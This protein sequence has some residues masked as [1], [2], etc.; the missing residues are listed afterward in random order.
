MKTNRCIVV[1]CFNEEAVL[2]L[3]LGALEELLGALVKE[4]L[5]TDF[6][7]LS[8]R[9]VDELLQFREVNLDLRG[10]SHCW[11]SRRRSSS[12][13]ALPARPAY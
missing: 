2:P 10:P 8:R 13:P 6:R 5:H 3:T 12:T 9:A 11:D 1:P 7:L 4:G